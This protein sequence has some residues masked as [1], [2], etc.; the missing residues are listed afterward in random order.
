M[1]NVIPI[2]EG[3]GEQAA[4]QRLV[5]RI[6]HYQG[7][8]GE[9]RVLKPLRKKRGDLTRQ[10]GLERHV[11]AALN[12]AKG[13]ARVLV[14]IDAEDDCA[15]RLGPEL[16]RRLESVASGSAV[17][18]VRQYENWLVADASALSGHHR[19]QASMTAPG[20]PEAIRNPK[21]WLG[22]RRTDGRSYSPTAHQARLTELVDIDVIRQ[23]CDSFDKF[24]REVKRL[25][26]S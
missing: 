5:Q 17:L 2:V 23:R 15:A 25:A 9:A 24:C 8:D 10:G 3:Q 6:L 20:N 12:K 18:A 4:V 19:F 22:D 14:L 11:K 7:C 13:E 21:Q 16:Q 26:T 1:R